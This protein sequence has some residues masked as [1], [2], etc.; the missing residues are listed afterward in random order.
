MQ[1]SYWWGV[2]GNSPKGNFKN[3]DILSHIRCIL[4]HAFEIQHAFKADCGVR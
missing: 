3:V 4:G 2:W 1:Y